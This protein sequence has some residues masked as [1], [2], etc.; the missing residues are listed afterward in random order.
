MKPNTKYYSVIPKLGILYANA[1]QNEIFQPDKFELL[2]RQR[3]DG[4][5]NEIY[6]DK[7]GMVEG[8]ENTLKL[9]GADFIL[10]GTL[11]KR[12][13]TIR[14]DA[15]LVGTL[16][17]KIISVGTATLPMND[18]IMQLYDDFPNSTQTFKVL[19]FAAEGW[20]SIGLVEDSS[21]ITIEA[22]GEWSMTSHPP[23]R[24]TAAG[25]QE[26]PSGWGD[27]RLYHDLNHGALI[28][29]VN[30]LPSLIMTIGTWEVEQKGILECRINDTDLKNN[31]GSQSVTIKAKR[32][33]K[34]YIKENIQ[35]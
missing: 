2:E 21:E 25:S 11:Q 15:R 32:I 1:L 22:E 18:Y 7:I 12:E 16:D 19:V 20:Q 17:G 28:C 9:S 10:L 8:N 3:V 13:Q 29:R 4:L 34:K 35:N 26:N 5:L 14:I 6:Y 27:Y 23:I 33:D 31:V 24:L 30:T